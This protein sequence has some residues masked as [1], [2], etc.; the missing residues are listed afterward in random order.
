MDS[1]ALFKPGW[2]NPISTGSQSISRPISYDRLFRP[3]TFPN[4]NADLLYA[5]F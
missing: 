5:S 2:G 4:R 3:K 1:I